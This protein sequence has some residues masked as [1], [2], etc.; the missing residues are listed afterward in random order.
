MKHTVLFL[1]LCAALVMPGAASGEADPSLLI[2]VAAEGAT[3]DAA[4]ARAGRGPFLL[5][6]DGTGVM[7]EAVAN[8]FTGSMRQAG[9]SVVGFLHDRRVRT[10]IAESFGAN[11][12]RA[13]NSRSMQSFEFRGKADD[14]VKAL[15]QAR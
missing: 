1:L 14:G 10:L 15:L 11:I 4:V 6:F 9:P 2:A 12:E 13:M 3:P 7:V 5:L 8:P